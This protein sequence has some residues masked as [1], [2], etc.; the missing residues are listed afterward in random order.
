MT[1]LSLFVEFV[2][3]HWT[4]GVAGALALAT[5]VFAAILL[6][7]QIAVPLY[8][9]GACAAGVY[10]RTGVTNRKNIQTWLAAHHDDIFGL[11]RTPTLARDP[12]VSRRIRRELTIRWLSTSLEMLAL[13]ARLPAFKGEL[14]QSRGAMSW[15]LRKAAASE[16]LNDT[17]AIAIEAVLGL[18]TIGLVVALRGHE[19]W[20]IT[21]AAVPEAYRG[22]EIGKMMLMMALDEIDCLGRSPVSV[23]VRDDYGNVVLFERLGFAAFD[24]Q[25]DGFVYKRPADYRERTLF[26]EISG[27]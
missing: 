7:W 22:Y 20:W 24:R 3:Q 8:G 16:A 19:G 6:G 14:Q 9:V 21:V 12:A 10:I 2:K 27:D 26:A 23:K 17:S 13:S 4:V 25:P 18:E 15:A 1:Q 11:T 5:A